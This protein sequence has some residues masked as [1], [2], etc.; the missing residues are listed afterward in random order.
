[1]KQYWVDVLISD[2]VLVEAES[3]S[4]AYDAARGLGY[5][6]IQAVR[7]ADEETP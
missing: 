5:S 7:M 3:E 1:M 2:T 6:Y 4:D